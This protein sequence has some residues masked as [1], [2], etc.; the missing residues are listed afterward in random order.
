MIS[1]VD[2]AKAVYRL[3]KFRGDDVEETTKMG[4]D[5]FRFSVLSLMNLIHNKLVSRQLPLLPSDITSADGHIPSRYKNVMGQCRQ[6][7]YCAALDE[8]LKDIWT[9]SSKD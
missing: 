4:I 1:N 9:I 7:E 2:A 8:Y 5:R 3:A 6:G